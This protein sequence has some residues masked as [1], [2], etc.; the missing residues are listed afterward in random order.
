M[1]RAIRLVVDTG[2]HDKHWS[3]DRMVAYFHR[4]TAMDEPNIQTEVDCY[5]AGPAQALAYK[6]GQSQFLK[7][8]QYA[9]DQPV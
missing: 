4:Y 3:R 5:I 7:L 8:R 6:L 1:W 2:V 9:K